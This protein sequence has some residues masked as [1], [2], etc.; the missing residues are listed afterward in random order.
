MLACLWSLAAFAQ[1]PLDMDEDEIDIPTNQKPNT[2]SDDD[3][4]F[5]QKQ[6]KITLSVD[7]DDSM[8]DFVADAKKKAP[9]P[10]HFHLTPD[11]KPPLADNF[12]IQVT[13]FNEHYVV[14]ELPV[15]VANGRAAFTAA[16]PGGLLLIG[17]ITGD[18]VRQVVTQLVTPDSVFESGPT[19]VFLKAALPLAARTTNLRFLVKA[20]EQPV[21]PAL[22]APGTKAPPK[23]PT[24][25]PPPAPP[26]ELFAR[27]TVFLR[28]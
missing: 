4:G 21:P 23:P 9:P 8:H 14:A 18:G 16:H 17:E 5:T 11:N 27:T 2:T 22:P 7:E 19:L 13:A 12:D 26:K 25:P 24:P 1:D 28:P 15:L 6:D 10:V 3:W 20:G